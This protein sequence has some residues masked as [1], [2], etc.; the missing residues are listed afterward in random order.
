MPGFFIVRRKGIVCQV[1][2]GLRKWYGLCELQIR[3]DIFWDN[4]RKC[5]LKVPSM[6]PSSSKYAPAMREKQFRFGVMR[7]V[8]SSMSSLLIIFIVFTPFL[9]G[10]AV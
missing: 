8:S 9:A 6:N 3:L 7:R 5:R 10:A 4:F 2:V 1:F